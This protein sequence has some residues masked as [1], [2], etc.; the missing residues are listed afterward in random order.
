MLFDTSEEA[1]DVAVLA[2]YA[3]EYGPEAEPPNAR[4]VYVECIDGLPLRADESGRERDSVIRG[5]V[6]GY[7][8]HLRERGFVFVHFR[9]PSPNDQECQIFSRCPKHLRVSHSIKTCQWISRLLEE[10]LRE[11]VVDSFHAGAHGGILNFPPTLLT[12][13]HLTTE[14]L[15]SSSEAILAQ[16]LPAASARLLRERLFV[17][18]LQSPSA[19]SHARAANGLQNSGGSSARP[20][21]APSMSSSGA[22]AS[23]AGGAAPGGPGGAFAASRKELCTFLVSQRLSFCSEPAARSATAAVL[24]RLLRQ[25]VRALSRLNPTP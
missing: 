11:A 4:R 14:C 18:R 17:A 19:C 24:A 9:A 23:G 21:M 7:L 20:M 22:F 6:C 13:A 1:G 5:V 2:V 12:P 10:A 3:N 25:Q 8:E 16:R 15:F